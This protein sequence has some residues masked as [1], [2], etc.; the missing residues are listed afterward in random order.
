MTTQQGSELFNEKSVNINGCH[1]SY[2]DTAGAGPVMVF[3]HA[4]PLDK[5]MWRGQISHFRNYCRVIAPDLRGFGSS[6]AGDYDSS[7]VLFASDL[8]ALLNELKIDKVIL[9]GLSMGGYIALHAATRHPERISHLILCST[10]CMAD[11]EEQKKARTSTIKKILEDGIEKFAGQFAGDTLN[12]NIPEN[13]EVIHN[14]ITSQTVKILAAGMSAM[15]QRQET[16]SKLSQLTM[17]VLVLEAVKDEIVSAAQTE[18]LY[19][20]IRH[21]QLCRLEDTG[22]ISNLESP[23][24]FNQYIERFLKLEKN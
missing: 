3:L 9:C 20:K 17:P 24:L 12:K 19:S 15:A 4:F 14:L 6:T 8:I 16:C 1:I 2:Y 18:L 10:H 7:I 13:R 5:R 11:S 23:V 22:H 21:S